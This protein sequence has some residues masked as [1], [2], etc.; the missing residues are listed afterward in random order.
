[1]SRSDRPSMQ[2]PKDCM[3]LEYS[4]TTVTPTR[5][6]YAMCKAFGVLFRSLREYGEVSALR[7][8][9]RDRVATA[10]ITRAADRIS[11]SDHRLHEWRRALCGL[12]SCMCTSTRPAVRSGV[13]RAVFFADA[14]WCRVAA[15]FF[16]RIM[17]LIRYICGVQS[18]GSRG[19]LG[20]QLPEIISAIP[21]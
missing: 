5:V 20:I 4:Q 12:Y 18:L 10:A 2:Q 13:A 19:N 3:R 7:V 11:K 21:F 15:A 6:Y 17:S 1:M 8:G 9:R 14:V 16:Y